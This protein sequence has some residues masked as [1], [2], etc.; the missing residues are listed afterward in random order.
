MN[1]SCVTF[2]ASRSNFQPACVCAMQ[3]SY[4]TALG[5]VFVGATQSFIVALFRAFSN[6]PPMALSASSCLLLA[7]WHQSIACNC[8][9]P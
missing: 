8:S 9:T 6:Q 1:A 5:A 2:M 3:V 4:E 7:I